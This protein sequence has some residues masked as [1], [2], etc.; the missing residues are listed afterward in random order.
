MSDPVIKPDEVLMMPGVLRRPRRTR[1][2]PPPE[3]ARL[4]ENTRV[5]KKAGD[6]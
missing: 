1:D 5:E 3:L 4:V 6:K 2:I